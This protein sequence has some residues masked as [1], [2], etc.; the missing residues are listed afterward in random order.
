MGCHEEEQEG[1][2]EKCANPELNIVSS[3]SGHEELPFITACFM[4]HMQGT[5]VQRL[6]ACIRVES[7][8]LGGAS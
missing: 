1:L 2:L 7:Q 8:Y 3:G 4:S 5:G 6:R